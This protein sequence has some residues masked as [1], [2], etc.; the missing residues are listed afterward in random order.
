MFIF[1]CFFV[2][3]TGH[4]HRGVNVWCAFYNLG[5]SPERNI[6]F[7]TSVLV[8]RSLFHSLNLKHKCQ[9]SKVMLRIAD[10]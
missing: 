10:V 6:T 9:R 5:C 8:V 2:C 4:A 7:S 3:F 1:V